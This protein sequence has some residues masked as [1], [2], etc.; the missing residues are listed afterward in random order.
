MDSS[1]S[2]KATVYLLDTLSLEICAMLF[3][4]TLYTGLL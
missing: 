3:G 4:R 2:L 1:P